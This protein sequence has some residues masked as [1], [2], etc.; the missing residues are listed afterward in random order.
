MTRRAIRSTD[1][2]RA[3]YYAVVLLF[4]LSAALLAAWGQTTPP[5][6]TTTIS[7][8]VYD[9]RVTT[10]ALPLP[11]V[12][13]YATVNPVA[14]LAAGAQ[15][16]TSTSA[17][18]TNVVAYT[19]TAVD[20][21]FT[22]TGVP[23]NATYT[24]VIQAGKWRRQFPQTSVAD[25]PLSG[26]ALHMPADH[27]QGDIPLIAIAT[28][29]ADGLEC[30]FHDMGIA[31][32]EFT[33]DTGSVNP[34]GRIHLYKGDKAPGADISASTPAES[35]LLNDPTL[36]TQYDMV[37][38]PCQGSPVPH[39][40][41][42]LSNIVDYANAGGRIFTTHLS[43]DVLDPD[44]PYLSPFPAVAK[45]HPQANPSPNNGPATVNTNF[46]DG[47]AL[48]QWLQNAGAIYNNTP[49]QIYVTTTRHDTD[50]VIP[51]TQSWLTLNNA[52][53]GDP[54]MQ[55]TF[56]TPV[57]AP[58]ANQCGRVLFNE[59]HVVNPSS[60]KGKVYPAECPKTTAM[61]A[62]EEM[63]EYALFDLSTFVQPV[64]VPT[65]SI[66]FTPSPLIVK[67]GDGAD[68][69]TVNVTNTSTNTP[70]DSSMQ[71]VLTL[72]PNMTA[73]ALA[74][75]SGSWTCGVGTLTC[76][77][78]TALAPGATDAVT[79]TLS[80]PNY[81]A[82]GLS[83]YTGQLVAT[84]SSATFS[85]NVVGSDTVIFQQQPAI[86]WA[87]PAPIPYGTP[88][89]ATQLDAS[90]TVAG[91]FSYNPPAGTVLAVGQQTLQTTLTPTDTTD[92]TTATASVSINIIPAA[93]QVNLTVTPNPA[94]LK[95]PVTLTATLPSPANPPT[96]TVVF[97]DGGAQI[98]S[99]TI[100]SGAASITISSLAA[101]THNVTAVYS[102]DTSYQP[103]TSA[104]VSVTIEDF[105]LTV[106][107][108]AGTGSVGGVV[109]Y[110]LN[111]A[112]VGGSIIPG[113]VSF[114]VTGLPLRSTV[115][116]TPAKVAAGSAATG[117]TMQVNLQSQAQTALPGSPFRRGI[118]PV[119]FGLLLLPFAG[120]LRRARS[121]LYAAL[122]V[123]LA[124]AFSLG[125]GGC[126]ALP[127]A[128]G[129]TLTLTAGSGSLT[130]SATVKLTVQ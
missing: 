77:R 62:Q 3:A 2:V 46:T 56:N 42:Q 59:Y 49:G 19:Y 128:E 24:L 111:V 12:L 120:R 92:Y 67:Q 58:L 116:F 36:M 102:G 41:N 20:G 31:D 66:T 124:L 47:A 34:D 32:T 71:L 28:G 97:M 100:S 26:L 35:T 22:L 112:P 29:G 25:T 108:G 96:G 75:A 68:Q 54:V 37:M 55:F 73:T 43:Y 126:G 60:P 84:A 125:I 53:A 45:W 91:T 16:L 85:N 40:A 119:A 5:P 106:L 80:V 51:P 52:A 50:G 8:T 127:K 78:T 98:G 10:D 7:G 63:L 82:G 17:T 57:G 99:A 44:V 14:P 30:V 83:S 123:L 114:T 122:I 130:H 4:L 9:P 81:P 18:P 48:A 90:S 94:L 79:L 107:T 88:L 103:A 65:L 38:F 27:T 64:V 101:G 117:V 115:A 70:V 13:V 93:P 11:H 105:A 86:T 72:P 6:P 61:S 76:T 129:Y 39:P 1:L 104:P 113:D 33:D 121:A 21:T 74:D 69:V 95:A 15:C 109:N 89:S 110:S 118:L 87:A 23:Q